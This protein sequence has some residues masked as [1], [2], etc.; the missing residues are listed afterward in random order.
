MIDDLEREKGSRGKGGRGEKKSGKIMTV[1]SE[2]SCN[3]SL[4]EGCSPAAGC[5]GGLCRSRVRGGDIAAP[6]RCGRGGPGERLPGTDGCLSDQVFG[7]FY[8]NIRTGGINLT[9]RDWDV[10]SE[11]GPAA[12]ERCSPGAF[13][14]RKEEAE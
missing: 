13:W 5:R 4:W 9:G 7:L 1:I 3:V 8:Q 2:N 14:A 6:R 11:T 12:E 10:Y